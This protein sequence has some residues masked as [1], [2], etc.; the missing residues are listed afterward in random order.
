MPKFLHVLIS[1]AGTLIVCAIFLL[2]FV[3]WMN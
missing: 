1:I 3:G 2:A